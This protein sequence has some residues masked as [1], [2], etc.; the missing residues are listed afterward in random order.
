[1][2][3]TKSSLSEPRQHLVELVH[4]VHF[5]RIEK[6]VVRGGQPVLSPP[7]RVIR[8]IRFKGES[9]LRPEVLSKDFVLKDQFIRLLRH[10]EEL[11]DGVIDV[12]EIQH[13]L[14]FRVA[15]EDAA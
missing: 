9:S 2:D 3:V 13:G 6:L 12:L 4:E 7:P 1:M 15:V 5:G 11:Q 10:L 14:P 8:E